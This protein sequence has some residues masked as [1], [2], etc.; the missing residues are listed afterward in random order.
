[1]IS[2]RTVAILSLIAW[3]SFSNALAAVGRTP[4]QFAVSSTGS[5]QYSIPIRT[6]PGM[7]GIQPNLAL[8]Y[9]SHLSYG[10]M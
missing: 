5:A 10:L 3:L 6:L 9:D 2:R 4:G 1:M 8:T 7:R